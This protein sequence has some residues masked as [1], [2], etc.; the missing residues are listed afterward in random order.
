MKI[1]YLKYVMMAGLAFMMMACDNEDDYKVGPEPAAGN[2]AAYFASSNVSSLTLTPEDYAKSTEMELK[3]ARTVTDAAA[4][5]P[6]EVVDAGSQFTF[7][8]AVEFAA[9]EAT[10]TIKVGYAGLETGVTYSFTIK[11]ADDYT[12]PYAQLDGSPVFTCSVMIANWKKVVKDALFYDASSYFPKTYSDIYV[13]EGQ[14]KFY[15]ENFMGSG[16][17]LGFTI[18]GA[19]FSYIDKSTWN[20]YFSLTDHYTEYVTDSYLYWYIVDDSG[21]YAK[22]DDTVTDFYLYGG[23]T[24]SLFSTIDM[25]G[26]LETYAGY[27]YGYIDYAD[28]TVCNGTYISMYWDEETNMTNLE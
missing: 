1:N 26:S 10:S 11:L 9:G 24:G 13:L 16:V 2:I 18:S 14:N 12:D 3:V 21:A 27:L 22:W 20:G 8:S 17:N 6:I 19:A 28:G 15:I 4:S 7:P 23:T 5:V 25:L